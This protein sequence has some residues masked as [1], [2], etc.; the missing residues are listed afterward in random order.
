MY[1]C[2]DM[3]KTDFTKL[4]NDYSQDVMNV[5]FFYLKNKEDAQDVLMEVFMHLMNKPPKNENNL[6]SYILQLTMRKSL[7]FYRKSSRAR[8]VSL[9]ESILSSPETSSEDEEKI[10][11]IRSLPDK[12]RSVIVLFY[13]EELSIIEIAKTLKISEDATK[14]R[15][16]RAREIL[17]EKNKDE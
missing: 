3:E 1:N 17:K 14:K 6:K 10:N 12:Y 8:F 5:A 15:L 7:D 16:Q 9:D 11:L 2:K 4:F 13:V